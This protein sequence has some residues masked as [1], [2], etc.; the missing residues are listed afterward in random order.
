LQVA[1][2]ILVATTATAMRRRRMN[3]RL[4]VCGR[5]FNGLQKFVMAGPVAGMAEDKAK[6]PGFSRAFAFLLKRVA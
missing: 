2:Y 1:I 3:A 5:Y 6:G 4:F